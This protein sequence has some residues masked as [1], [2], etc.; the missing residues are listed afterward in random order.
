MGLKC[1]TFVLRDWEKASEYSHNV[2]NMSNAIFPEIN[3]RAAVTQFAT[4][5]NHAVLAKHFNFPAISVAAF[6]LFFLCHSRRATEELCHWEGLNCRF[7]AARGCRFIWPR[8]A[9]PSTVGNNDRSR[10][11]FIQAPP[12]STTLWLCKKERVIWKTT[13]LIK[14]RLLALPFQMMIYMALESGKS[15]IEKYAFLQANLHS[16]SRP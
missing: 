7:C 15:L 4:K 10:K 12:K 16:R 1:L 6:Q 5:K 11:S 9:R 3:F 13:G 8:S 14:R 2:L